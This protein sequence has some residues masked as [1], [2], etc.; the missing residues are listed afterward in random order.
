MTLSE[1][2][3][4]Y[5]LL[6]ELTEAVGGAFISSWQGTHEWQPRRRRPAKNPSRH[7]GDS[8]WRVPGQ[9]R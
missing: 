9:Y 2:Q 3:V 7:T 6:K 5:E 1:Y 4:A 8:T